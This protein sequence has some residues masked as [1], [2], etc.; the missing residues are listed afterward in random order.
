VNT[1]LGFPP[2][3]E[4]YVYEVEIPDLLARLTP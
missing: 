1:V 2:D 4:W 3:R